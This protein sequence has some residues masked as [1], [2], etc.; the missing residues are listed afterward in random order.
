MNGLTGNDKYQYRELN[1]HA[2]MDMAV[3]DYCSAASQGDTD[4]VVELLLIRHAERELIERYAEFTVAGLTEDGRVQ[5]RRFGERLRESRK[6]H[7]LMRPMTSHIGRAVET[8]REI[9]KGFYPGTEQEVEVNREFFRQI[10]EDDRM[11]KC[12][13]NV[14]RHVCSIDFG[15]EDF[16]DS[17][18]GRQVI[19]TL[20]EPLYAEIG[21]ARRVAATMRK[22]DKRIMIGV[23]HDLNIAALLYTIAP[24]TYRESGGITVGYLEGLEVS[25]CRNIGGRESVE[26][27]SEG[28][29]I[30]DASLLQV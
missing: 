10:S 2:A 11:W 28:K 8:G 22:G 9:A 14:R 27:R 18:E 1:K 29:I 7:V 30:G 17:D 21:K 25:V 20:A 5:A 6:G 26:L 23:A 3:A 16:S 24:K 12:V 4:T 15:H 13:K 19:D